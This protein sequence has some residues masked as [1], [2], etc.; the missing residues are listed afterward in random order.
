MPAAVVDVSFLTGRCA[1]AAVRSRKDLE[2]PQ[3]EHLS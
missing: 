2:V 3:A 1:Q